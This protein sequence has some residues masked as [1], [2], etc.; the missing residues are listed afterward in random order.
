MGDKYSIFGGVINDN[1]N[2]FLT[3]ATTHL[4]R[5]LIA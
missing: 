5:R 1:S 2:I 4:I 3:S